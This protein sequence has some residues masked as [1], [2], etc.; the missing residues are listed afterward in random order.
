M[1]KGKGLTLE[2]IVDTAEQMV[3]EKGYGEFSVRD[4]A[5][6]LNVKA[7]SLY[8]Y[9]ESI[10]AV[11]LEI[12]TRAAV[13]L[14]GELSQAIEGKERSGA[15]EA[16]AYAYRDFVRRNPELYRAILDLPS[17]SE[18]AELREVGKASFQPIRTVVE[19]YG[20]PRE[21]GVH[22]ARCFRGALH[23]F[24]TL[25]TD[26]YFTNRSIRAEKSF[27]FLIEGYI[28]WLEALSE[29][30]RKIVNI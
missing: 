7:A 2:T 25:Q 17:L 15:L 5:V 24:V 22:F 3:E 21:T 18:S 30:Q 23:G 6:R 9:I 13:R 14:N 28:N 26:G 19:Q 12:G 27:Q 29:E 16:L 11:N 10:E 4:L 8:R 20:I 1:N